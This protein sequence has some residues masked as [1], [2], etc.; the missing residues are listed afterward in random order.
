MTPDLPGGVKGCPDLPGGNSQGK[1][2]A[3]E[4]A[5]KCQPC[6]EDKQKYEAQYH[7]Q[8]AHGTVGKM[9]AVPQVLRKCEGGQICFESG[10]LRR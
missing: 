4:K 9:D 8:A 3:P 5:T 10:Y 2:G 6:A 1:L 7:G